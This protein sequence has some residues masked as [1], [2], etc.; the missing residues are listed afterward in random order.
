[1][2]ALNISSNAVEQSQPHRVKLEYLD[3]L[4]LHI[5]PIGFLTDEV[6]VLIELLL[7]VVDESDLAAALGN[8]LG[9]VEHGKRGHYCEHFLTLCQLYLVVLDLE[10]LT[11]LLFVM[12]VPEICIFALDFG[13][14]LAQFLG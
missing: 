12:E 10:L 5:G 14:E 4:N 3:K 9:I 6:N 11:Q 1:M 7:F 13:Q 2:Q 8:Y